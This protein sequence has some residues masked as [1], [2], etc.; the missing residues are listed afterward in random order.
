[1]CILKAQIITNHVAYLL[2]LPATACGLGLVDELGDAVGQFV[3]ELVRLPLLLGGRGRQ[4]VR[5]LRQRQPLPRLADA[6]LEV[7]QHSLTEPEELVG[8]LL[9]PAS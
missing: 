5:V 6:R 7:R 3:H 8:A 2:D 1:M 9:L 4:C